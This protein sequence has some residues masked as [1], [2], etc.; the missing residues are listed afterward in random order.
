M[1]TSNVSA[2]PTIQVELEAVQAELKSISLQEASCTVKTVP[3]EIVQVE[4]R[5]ILD[6]IYSLDYDVSQ[7]T[8]ESDA[9][10]VQ[11]IQNNENKE[12]LGHLEAQ[13]R[14]TTIDSKPKFKDIEYKKPKNDWFNCLFPCLF[15]KALKKVPSIEMHPMTDSETKPVLKP[16]FV[17]SFEFNKTM[18]TIY[19][20][21]RPGVDEF[22]VRL[23]EFFEIIIFT[24]SIATYADS[25]LDVL[26]KHKDL[27]VLGRDINHTTIID[28]LPSSYMFQPA[29]AI[30]ITSWYD[31]KNDTELIDLIPFLE[32]LKDVDNFQTVLDTT[33]EE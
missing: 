13:D 24:A 20:M 5:D 15:P 27:S 19:V 7:E 6:D 18:Q 3:V 4:T 11:Q 28:N 16:D 25:V 14:M 26:D 17:T 12:S 9:V 2:E 32:D 33:I 22:L 21:K 31:D 29:N 23:A 1:E 8:I 30:P 10:E